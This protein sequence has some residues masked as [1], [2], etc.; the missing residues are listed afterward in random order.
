MKIKEF[1]TLI[2]TI[3][4]FLIV[5]LFGSSLI[6]TINMFVSD[7]FFTVIITIVC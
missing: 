7:D 1:V 2:I 5:I 3:K 6:I 4:G